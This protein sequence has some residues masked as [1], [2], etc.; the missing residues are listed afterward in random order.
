MIR[1]RPEKNFPVFNGDISCY[2]LSFEIV[3]GTMKR[4]N[5]N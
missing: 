5:E 2:W 4:K 3:S 1:L